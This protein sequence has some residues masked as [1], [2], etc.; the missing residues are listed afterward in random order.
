MPLD[1]EVVQQKGICTGVVRDAI[2]VVIGAS[3]AVK[4]TSNGCI[5]DIDGKF[6][7][8]DVAPGSIIQVSFVGYVTQEVKWNGQPLNITLKEDSKTLDEVVVVGFGSQKKANL[9]GAVATVKMD[10]VLGSRPLTS[11]ADALQGSVPGLLVSNGGNA[12]G[13]AKSF[14]IRGA[15]SVGIKNTN[16]SYGNT[17]SPLVLIDNVEGDIDM[18]NPEDIETVSVL[19]DAAS[20]AIYGARAAGG[21]ILITTKRPKDKAKFQ[22]NYNNNFAFANA[23]NLPKQASLMDYLQAYSDCQGDDFWASNGQSVSKWMEY[24][25][26]YKKNPSSFN[27]QGDGVYKDDE[28]AVYYLNEKDLVKNMLETSFQQTHNLSMAGATEKLRYRL[29]GSFVNNDG[30]L[31]TDKDQYRRLNVSGFVSA[32]ITKWFTQEATFSYAHSKKTLPSSPTGGIYSTRL[33]SFYPEGNKPAGILDAA[34]DNQP[35]FTPKN[36]ILWSNTTN[37]LNDNPRIFLKSILKPMKGLEVAFEYTFDKKVY[38][39]SYYTGQSSY[40][41]IQGGSMNTIDNDHLDKTKRYTDYNAFNLYATYNFALKDHKFK[42]MAGFNQ[43]S[44]Y[45]EEMTA[46]SYGQAVVEVPSLGAGTSTLTASDTYNEY[47]VRGG[48]FRVNYNYK[49]RYLVEANGRYDGS[50]K[51]PKDSRYGFFPSVSVGWNIAQE[52]FMEST[53]SWLGSLKLRGSY[54]MIGNQNVPSY[55]FIP[56]MAI[57]NKYLG[58][59]TGGD[60]VTAIT[61]LPA[62]VSSNFTWEKVRTLD[63]G[64][65]VSVFNNRL[66]STFDWYQR[67]TDGMLAPGMQLPAVIGAS[68]PYQNTAD[69]RTRGWEL[70]L[71]WR[72]RV[73]EVGYRVGFNLSDSQSKIMKYDSNSSKILTSVLSDGTTFWNFYEG[74][75]LGE[76]WGYEFDGFYTVDDFVDTKSWKLKDGV[77]SINGYGNLRPGDVKFKNLKDD[78]NFTNVITNGN[79]T[80]DNPGDRKVIGNN[81]P[82]YLYGITLGGNFKG[83]DLNIFMQG[84][85]KR[86]AWIA[87]T[88]IFPLYA[89]SKFVPLYEGLNN[90]WKP[91]DAAND[92]YTCANPGAEFPRIY[93]SYGNQGSNYRQSDKYLSDASYFRIKNVTLSYT[94]PKTLVQ[95]ASLSSLKAFVSVENLAT[96]SSLPKGIDPETLSWNYP[97]YRTISFGIN[98]SL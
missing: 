10:E 78:E 72:D 57:N 58:W 60:Y 71:N 51:F 23:M 35:F 12:A 63:F 27:V 43:E 92:D 38:D 59:V 17:I 84:T 83:F 22:L 90:Y 18:L 7:I 32:D 14:Q 11:A 3:V 52:S 8:K 28:G 48:F 69:M 30:V 73:G 68:A 24:L 97:A 93:G 33:V 40:T 36:Q 54:G 65:D 64:L 87:N 88:L 42:V 82:R 13:T 31:I 20:S 45:R 26:E 50:S 37:T 80:V 75:D 79:N 81:T 95:K 61:S 39:Y 98:L 4:G 53:H 1:M 15:Y 91:V 29:S 67:N 25:Q 41:T 74:K 76:I 9:T 47:A 89:D 34:S 6:S 21:V 85:A 44:S 49:D 2:D 62:L 70:S 16:G 96:F 56:T 5:T 46:K 86:D 66:T 55:S 94:F 77:T 19:K